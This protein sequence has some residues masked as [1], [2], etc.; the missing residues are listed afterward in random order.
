MKARIDALLDLRMSLAALKI[1]GNPA[2]WEK[3]FLKNPNKEIMAQIEAKDIEIEAEKIAV[4]TENQ[5]RRGNI[6]QV[7]DSI[8]QIKDSDK[9]AWEKKILIRLVKELR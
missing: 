5:E 9:P 1:S 3:D 2:K 7:K 8:Q 4:K 6:S